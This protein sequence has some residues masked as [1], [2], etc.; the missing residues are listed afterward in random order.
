MQVLEFSPFPGKKS[1][2]NAAPPNIYNYSNLGSEGE[3]V[4]PEKA[5]CG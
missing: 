3:I 1:G 4:S 5:G 2:E